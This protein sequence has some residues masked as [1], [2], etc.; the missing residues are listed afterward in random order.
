MSDDVACPV[1]TMTDVLSGDD[2]LECATCGHEWTPTDVA[3]DDIEVVDANGTVLS[4]G[5]AVSLVQ[6]VAL[7]GKSNAIKAG[8]KIK[9]IRI[10]SGDHEL[11]CKVDGRAILLKAK[12]VKK[13]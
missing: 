10:V 5:D 9:N 11:D 4:T 3:A 1:C 2:H 13:V 7:D 12:F 8:T 6:G